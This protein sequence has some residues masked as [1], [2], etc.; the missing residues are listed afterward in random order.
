MGY[1]SLNHISEIISRINCLDI[2]TDE[3]VFYQIDNGDYNIDYKTY[4]T[5]RDEMMRDLQRNIDIFNKER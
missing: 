4:L 3:K 1:Y 5:C 2:E